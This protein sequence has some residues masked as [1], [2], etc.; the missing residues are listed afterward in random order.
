M[1]QEVEP[2]KKWVAVLL[3]ILLAGVLGWITWTYTYKI[4]LQKIRF[5]LITFIINI[6]I[7]ATFNPDNSLFGSIFIVWLV[8]WVAA[9]IIWPLVDIIIRSSEWY[10]NYPN[11]D[12]N[13]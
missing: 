7:I 13:E 10:K 5:F 12:P 8:I 6:I 4:D 3:Y 11:G 2:K 1:N 9:A